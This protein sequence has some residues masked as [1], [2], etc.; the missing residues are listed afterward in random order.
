MKKF[1]A[2]A[3]SALMLASASAAVLAA[4]GNAYEYNFEDDFEGDFIAVDKTL[5]VAPK[6]GSITVAKKDD[7][8]TLKFSHPADEAGYDCFADFLKEGN[9]AYGLGTQFVMEYDVLFESTSENMRWQIC[10]SRETP[11]AGTQFQQVGYVIGSD[12]RV[13]SSA[14]ETVTLAN[15][16]LNKWYRFAAAFDQSNDCFSLYL[17][18]V[19]LAKDV[20]YNVADTSAEA[21]TQLRVAYQSFIGES[22]AY[23]DNVEVYAGEEPRNVSTNTPVV[24]DTTAEAV[25]DAATDAATEA[26]TTDAASTEN[27]SAAATAD[28]AVVLAAVSAIAASGVVVFKKKH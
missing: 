1:F 20:D 22:V 21:F 4:D 23:I 9:A 10:C 5:N 12:L 18:G 28:V 27:G 6:N 3:L 8:M 25:T 19:C 24:A 11:S 7:T 2:L 15:L 17:D 13:V 14:D 16:E 26:A